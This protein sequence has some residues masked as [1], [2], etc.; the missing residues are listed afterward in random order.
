MDHMGQ[1]TLPTTFQSQFPSFE[2][3][4]KMRTRNWGREL[5]TKYWVCYGWQSLQEH[6]FFLYIY[7]KE[8]F[9]SV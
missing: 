6:I 4:K 8:V 1:L 2:N 7:S 3:P 5:P 9:Q